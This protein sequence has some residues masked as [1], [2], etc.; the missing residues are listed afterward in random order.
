MTRPAFLR[1]T[2][3]GVL[4]LLVIPALL[5]GA[6]DAQTAKRYRNFQASVYTREQEVAQMGDPAWLEPRWANIQSQVKVSKIYL[7]THRDH[8]LVDEATLQRAIAFF[9]ARGVQ[10][11]GG[12]TFTISEPNRFETF[13]YSNPEHRAWVKKVVEFTAQHFDELI[14]DDFFFTSCKSDL[15][16]KAKGSRSWTHYR[17]DLMKN[18]ARDLVIGPAKAKNPHIKVVIKYPNW[19]EH[20]Q[21]LGFN[22]EAEPAMFDGIYTGTET[23]DAVRSAQHLQPYLGYQIFRYFDN[24]RPGHNGGGWVDTGGAM[25]VDRYA[26][27]L[28]LTL[29][30]KAPEMTLFDFRQLQTPIAER[31]RGPWHDRRTS[32]DFDGMM[33][34]YQQ[35]TGATAQPP[36]FA[37]PA[38][39]ALDQ[40][41]RFLQELGKP[42]GVKGYRP[43]HAT[44][45]DFLHNYLGMAGI[46]ID[47]RPEFPEDAD[48]VLL[49]QSAAHDPKIV[50]KIERHLRKGKNVVITSGLLQALQAPDENAA[51]GNN[52]G[53]HGIERIA[54]IRNTGRKAL[55]RE[56]QTSG[57]GP[58][59]S[60]PEPILIP[61]IG[62][63]TNDS[64]ELVSALAGPNGWPL[65]HDADYG[66]GHLYVLTI[67]DNFAD[68]YRLPAPVLNAIR[69][70]VTKDLPVRVDGPANVALFVYDNDTFIVESFLD[71]PVDVQLVLRQAGEGLKDIQSGEYLTG[72]VVPQGTGLR[73][74]PDGGKHR[75]TLTLEPHSFRVFRAGAE[76]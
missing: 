28:W 22:L 70:V 49:T 17:L 31:L 13:C 36:T 10:V 23:R 29:F 76:R 61:Q 7:E 24:L 2:F 38:G 39:I 48:T 68:L 15:E 42:I 75:Y 41:D 69:R 74:D 72:Q 57:F 16:I 37:L 20:F 64:W 52:A 65:L 60:I 26:E 62:Y 11:A 55:V 53:S 46:P 33:S 56:F 63:L 40:V 66:G 1:R 45:E 18:A 51:H 35:R 21:G 67:P 58:L 71:E 27:Q 19:Y 43:F 47:L 50:D 6:L 14:L 3:H 8:T 32:F 54:E 30:A 59:V 34:A 9:K 5:P 44:G 4:A 73:A 12:I 25:T